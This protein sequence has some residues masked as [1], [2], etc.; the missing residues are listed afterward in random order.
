MNTQAILHKLLRSVA[1][2]KRSPCITYLLSDLTAL[3]PWLAALA[4]PRNS[5][6][7][8]SPSAMFVAAGP[9][10][11]GERQSARGV[12]PRV[13]A[14]SRP[15]PAA[16]IGNARRRNH[17]HAL[18]ASYR[19]IVDARRLSLGMECAPDRDFRSGRV[20]TFASTPPGAW[21]RTLDGPAKRSGA[22]ATECAG[23]SCDRI[24]PLAMD[25][26]Q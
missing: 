2:I 16:D 21:S 3:M 20:G 10:I 25:A 18:T 22:R 24:A 12:D 23:S 6:R 7:S 11:I 9:E 15:G 19:C 14:V 13:C 17:A 8:P 26:A 5:R 4:T 1:H